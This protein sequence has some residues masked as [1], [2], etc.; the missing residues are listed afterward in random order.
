MAK[1]FLNLQNLRATNITDVLISKISDTDLARFYNETVADM[2]K[3][4]SIHKVVTTNIVATQSIYTNTVLPGFLATIH[5][6]VNGIQAPFIGMEN[7][8]YATEINATF[9]T[10]YNNTL[11][12][13]PTPTASVTNGL[14]VHYWAKIPEIID[15]AVSSTS[16]VDIDDKDWAVLS[17]GIIAKCYEKLTI[18][19][20]SRREELI[21]INSDLIFKLYDKLCKKYEDQ[22]EKYGNNAYLINTE[23]QKTAA[24]YEN[25]PYPSTGK[26][27]K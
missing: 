13:S 2:S 7:F 8:E 3:H 14:V 21:D 25:D 9:H 4:A 1:T 20:T 18:Y 24:A 11:I 6:K 10:V 27:N 12:I 17:A 26:Q 19:L 5:V 23:L 16:L 22:L 15:A